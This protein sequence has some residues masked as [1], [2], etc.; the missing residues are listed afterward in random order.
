MPGIQESI[1][2][3]WERNERLFRQK[4]EPQLI[5]QGYDGYVALMRKGEV[6]ALCRN[7]EEAAHKKLK[8]G[9]ANEECTLHD[10]G[11]AT[12]KS[13]LRRLS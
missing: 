4:H 7:D 11:A 5:K 10:I 12:S 9:G 13:V 2:S 6:V 3:L 8:L 1:E